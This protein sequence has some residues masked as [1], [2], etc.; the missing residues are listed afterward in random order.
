MVWEPLQGRNASNLRKGGIYILLFYIVVSSVLMS[1]LCGC[2][3]H[4]YVVKPWT[5]SI[6][7]GDGS[8]S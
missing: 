7:E 6:R 4:A 5:A 8:T 3:F 2:R 1:G